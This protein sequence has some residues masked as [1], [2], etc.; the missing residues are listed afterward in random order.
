MDIS[1]KILSDI[2]I[3]NKY[4]K[5]N[6]NLKRR[7]T[8]EE[9]VERNL[10]MHID[11]FKGNIEVIKEINE[12]YRYVYERKIL[13][14][15]RAMQFSGRPIDLMPSRQYNC[16]YMAVNHP[17]V[18][19][20]AMFLLLG[21]TGVGYSV[22]RHH[23]EKLPAIKKPSKGKTRRYVIDDSITGWSDAIK[24]LMK[25]Y[26]FGK[27]EPRFDYSD[28]RQKG[29]ELITSGGKA[30]GPQPLKDCIHHIKGILDSKE[31]GEQLSTLEVHD[32]ICHIADAVLAGGIRRAACISL[33]DL[34]DEDMLTCKF[35]NW[36]ELNPQRGRANNSVLIIR[37]KITD[38]EF[39]K[40]WKKIQMSGSGEPGF[41]FS[42]DK[43]Y[44]VNPC[45]FSGDMKLQTEFGNKTF[46]EL[47]LLDKIKIYNKNGI[48][49]NGKV[50]KTGEKETI[51]LTNTLGE[52]IECTPEHRFM[53]TEGE[54][55]EA[56]FL[57]NL[58][59]MPY[60]DIRNHNDKFV[61]YGYIQGDGATGR[62]DS[63]AHKGLEIYIG[64]KDKD[65]ADLFNIEF[66]I[67]KTNYYTR[68]FNETLRYLEFNTSELPF[69]SLP[70]TF[71]TWSKENQLSFLR[72]MYSANGS[73][74]TNKRISYKTTCKKLV[75]Q[76]KQFFDSIG[77]IT[78]ITTNKSKAVTFN[79]GTYTCKESYDLNI[80]QYNSIRKFA[81]LIGFVH[82]Y[83]NNSLKELLVQRSPYIIKI[84]TGSIKSV[85]DF[86]IQ[87]DTH[88]GIV[89]GYIAHN[90]EIALKSEQFCNLSEANI[91][92]VTTQEELNNRV[93]AAATIGTLQ[94]SYTDFHYL[95]DSWKKNTEKDALLGVSL[96]G[97]ASG[98][99]KDLDLSEAAEVVNK[100]NEKIAKLIGINKSSRTTCLKP[101][102][103]ASLVFGC[104]SGIHAYHD[105]FY[106]RRMRIG[107]DEAIYTYLKENCPNLIVDDL[108]NNK[109]GIIE[110]PVKA[111]DNA[112]LRTESPLDLLERIKHFSEKWVKSGFRRGENNHNV[113]A[114]VSIK[115]DEWEVVGKW[116]WENRNSYNGLSV[117]PYFGGSYVQAPFESIDKDEYERRLKD[118][119]QIDLSKVIEDRDNTNLTGE[120]A[121][122]GGKC[123][124]S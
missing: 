102:G 32:I 104:S 39:Y 34:D 10:K 83:K 112:I 124:I 80:T 88:W 89:N 96:T 12:A 60:L 94:S 98:T 3:Y 4:A 111:P 42:N 117:L 38:D 19:S 49:H 37:H 58:R 24:M 56:K 75:D 26:F 78:Y 1:T 21:G 77:I 47:A 72:G 119:V 106:I 64:K 99:F 33:F 116:M 62:L 48:L 9:I 65:I 92:D 81:K 30:P 79:S 13:P 16:S 57:K 101:S 110:I 103:T 23:V 20:E 76:L 15:M 91:S 61:Q 35:G 11:K 28:I 50:W 105:Q 55:V 31:D 108:M 54:T 109:Q 29:A 82:E 17:A 123:E 114:T 5:Y 95:R 120:I 6:K 7:E 52:T 67:N 43:E 93:K 36:W 27:P 53:T 22:Q 25:A 87:D 70:E 69:R 122:S 18:F 84:Q 90:C 121:C 107:K 71:N 59:I 63:F 46:S 86:N 100:Q 66:N 73:I 85:Y 118:L 44:G 41:V 45:C 74:I 68:G 14:S 2:I 51:I 113:S 8:F 97:V 40:L 115:D